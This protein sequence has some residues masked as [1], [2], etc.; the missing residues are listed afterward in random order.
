MALKKK[1]YVSSTFE[2]LKEHRARVKVALEKAG[3]DVA[4]MEKYPAFDERPNAAD[5]RFDFRK[6]RHVVP[7]IGL[8]I[9]RRGAIRFAREGAISSRL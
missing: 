7:D 1:V 6:L 8:E 3:Y 9:L 5:H 2:D 4:C